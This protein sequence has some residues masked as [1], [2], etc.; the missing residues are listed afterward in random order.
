[1][2]FLLSD[3][4]EVLTEGDAKT[5][6]PVV[7]HLTGH[8]SVEDGGAR[9]GYTEVEAEKPPILIFYVELHGKTK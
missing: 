8:Q 6:L 5:A 3:L 9:Q 2:P 4:F 1:M 7:Q